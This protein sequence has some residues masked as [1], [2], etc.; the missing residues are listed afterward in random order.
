MT[1]IKEVQDYYGKTL[2]GSED[3]KTNACCTVINYSPE[4]KQVLALISEDVVSHYYGCGLTIPPRVKGL[5]VL[6]LGS[7]SGRDCFLLSGLVSSEGS[8]VGVD[9]TDAQ[10]AIANRNYQYHTDKFGYQTANVEFRKGEIERLE[11]VGLVDGEFDLII[12]NCVL[13]LSTDKEAVLRQA[14]RVLKEGG[15]FYFSDVYADRR[16]PAELVDDP[17]LYGECLSGALYWQDFEQL[18]RIVGFTDPRV[19]ESSAIEM[20]T[21]ELGEKVGSIK[22]ASVT[23]RLLKLPTLELNREDYGQFVIYKGTVADHKDAFIFDVQNTF[24]TG[25]KVP[26]CGNTFK[27]LRDSRYSDDFSF[28]GNFNT[29]LGSFASTGKASPIIAANVNSK[30][31][32]C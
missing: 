11:D 5:R 15:E 24:P 12:S 16:T 31:G 18:A 2:Q 9:M 8:V 32:C 20:K 26:V 23:Y 17:V 14:Y 13:N 19:V 10:L 27:M 4:I 21:D 29:H 6:D 30:G 28:I 25:E 7:G 3:L 1:K 22:F